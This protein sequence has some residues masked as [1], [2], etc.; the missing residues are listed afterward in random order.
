MIKIS[1]VCIFLILASAKSEKVSWFNFW[2]LY[3][4]WSI[5]TL[6]QLSVTLYY[7]ALCPYSVAFVTNQ[8]NPSYETFKDHIDVTFVPYGKAIVS[9]EIELNNLLNSKNNILFLIKLTELRQRSTFWMP[10][11]PSRMSRKYDSIMLTV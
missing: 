11:W 6:F 7:E 10:T 4:I 3:I 1:V 8:L 5:Y 9:V 2:L